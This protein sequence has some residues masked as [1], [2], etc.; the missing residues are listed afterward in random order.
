MLSLPKTFGGILPDMLHHFP[1]WLGRA[2]AKLFFCAPIRVSIVRSFVRHSIPLNH[3]AEFN[4]SCYIIFPHGKGVREQ[5][6]FSVR[7]SICPSRYL[8]LNHWAE[9]NQTCYITFP[10]DK[11]VREQYYF[12]LRPSICSSRY[13]LLNHWAEFNQ[14]CYITFL[15]GKGVQEQ[16]YFSVRPS[17]V[18]PSVTPS[19]LNHWAEFSQTFYITLPYGK[20]ARATLFVRASVVRPS[21][22]HAISS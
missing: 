14:P 9:F 13:H 18:Q 2:R 3:C 21:V 6:Y 4:Q 22:R 12:S 10:H 15:H 19:L 11:G 8:L 20:S 16:R 17:S 7:P 1:S 5:R